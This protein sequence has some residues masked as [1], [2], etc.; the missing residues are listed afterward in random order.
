MPFE[1]FEKDGLTYRQATKADFARILAFVDIFLRR[2]YLVR[3]AELERKLEVGTMLI[4]MDAEKL[5]SWAV[6]GKNE[7]LWNLL[8]HPKYRGRHIGQTIVERFRPLIIRSKSDQSTG[9][10]TPFYRKLGYR[11]VNERQGKNRNI[12]IM[13][14]VAEAEK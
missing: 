7:S 12:T 14:R 1:T 4:V 9:D 8:V 3:R 11:I 10:P 6:M 13:Q 2:D 5:V